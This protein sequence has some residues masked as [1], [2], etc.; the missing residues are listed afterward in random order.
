MSTIV[1]R[2]DLD[3]EKC[4][5]KIR[6]VLCKIQDKV[7]IRSITYD[8]KSKTV[9]ISGP[10][11]A[12]EVADRLT[13]NAGKVIRSSTTSTSGAEGGNQKH[14]TPSNAPTKTGKDKGHGGGKPEKKQV[15]FDFDDMSDDDD[16]DF[17]DDG[18]AHGHGN[19]GAGGHGGKP[20]SSI[21]PPRSRP[22]STPPAL[23]RP[24]HSMAAAAA[25]MRMMPP[26]GM[27]APHHHHQQQPQA[28][29]VPSIWPAPAAAPEWGYSAPQQ[30]G[31]YPA[32]GGYYG[33]VPAAAYG[34]GAPAYGY[35][36]SPYGQPQYYEEEPSAGCSVM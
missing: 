13:S 26:A 18:P 20:R 9:T 19:H 11:D 3:C 34:Y 30:Y 6:K 4:Y 36:R 15:K 31:G 17:F 27:M 12:E 21:P 32:G 35:G 14:V 25:P 7:S 22:G 29:A 10:F 5:K 28:M 33:G 8:E 23:A 2:V 16:D 1:M 24:C